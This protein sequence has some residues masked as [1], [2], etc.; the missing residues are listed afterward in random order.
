MDATDRAIA[1]LKELEGFCTN[2]YECGDG[3]RTI[4]YG[5]VMHD[6]DPPYHV[7]LS[8]PEADSILRHDI[9]RAVDAVNALVTVPLTQPQFDALVLFTYNVGTH[10]FEESTALRTLNDRLYDH[11]PN[12]IL[13]WHFVHGRSSPGLY[14]R[15]LAEVVLWDTPAEEYA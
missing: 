3:R 6:G 13:R 15:R 1:K 2:P 8:A 9:A 11:V 12:E 10:A 14:K 7:P 4:G 5:H